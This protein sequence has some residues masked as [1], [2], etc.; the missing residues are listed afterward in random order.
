MLAHTGVELPRHR[1]TVYSSTPTAS[2]FFFSFCDTTPG[3]GVGVSQH[4]P[5]MRTSDTEI[6]LVERASLDVGFTSLY[7]AVRLP[8]R[9]L[10]H[11]IEEKVDGKREHQAMVGVGAWARGPAHGRALQLHPVFTP[12]S[13]RADPRLTPG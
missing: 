7:Y 4:Y 10:P 9:P 13:P 2:R 1:P 11:G 12:G 8:R 3:Q 6:E 5:S